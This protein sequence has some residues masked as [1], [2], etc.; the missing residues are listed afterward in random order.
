MTDKE[1]ER[2]DTIDDVTL[3]LSSLRAIFL[4]IT[5]LAQ[6]EESPFVDFACFMAAKLKEINDKVLTL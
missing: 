1:R 6:T 2:R 3:T 4:I 5:D